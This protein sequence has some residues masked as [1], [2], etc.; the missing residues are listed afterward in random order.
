VTRCH[1]CWV[2]N[3]SFISYIACYLTLE[4]DEASLTQDDSRPIH[5]FVMTD[6]ATFYYRFMII[7]PIVLP[8]PSLL[9][10]HN[11]YYRIAL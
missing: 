9:I 1:R 6:N 7:R 11:F 3:A 4:L 10:L 8:F 5:W 2:P